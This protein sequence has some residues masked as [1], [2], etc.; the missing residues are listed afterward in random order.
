MDDILNCPVCGNKFK[1]NH[2]TNKL[3]HPINKTANYAE[4]QCGDGHNHTLTLWTDKSNRKVDLIKLSLGPS[5]S[6]FLE[7]DFVN[8]KCRIICA[9]DGE[10]EYI[11]IPKMIE[12][13]FPTL[14]K[15]KEKV[16]LYVVFS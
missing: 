15:L 2:H 5:Y 10:Y 16:A 6:R 1:T 3:L 9:Q 11:D 12:P 4:R 8:Q 7:I 14:T 13:D